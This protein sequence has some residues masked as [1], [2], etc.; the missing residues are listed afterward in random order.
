MLI[1]KENTNLSR[2]LIL[3]WKLIKKT[4]HYIIA[5]ETILRIIT[6]AVTKSIGHILVIHTNI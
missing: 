4:S 3:K 2:L 6:S 1:L 5:S